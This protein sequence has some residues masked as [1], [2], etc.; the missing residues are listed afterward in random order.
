[1][2]VAFNFR[3]WFVREKLFSPK[4]R[5]GKKLEGRVYEMSYFFL[6][7]EGRGD[8]ECFIGIFI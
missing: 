8:Y 5:C 1:M 3:L 2:D 6:T 7:Y 4:I